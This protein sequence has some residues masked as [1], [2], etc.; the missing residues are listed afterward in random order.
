MRSSVVLDGKRRTT[1]PLPWEIY[2]HADAHYIPILET[3]EA[4]DTLQALIGTKES[5][6]ALEVSPDAFKG[7]RQGRFAVKET[8]V[9]RLLLTASLIRCVSSAGVFNPLYWFFQPSGTLSATLGYTYSPAM[10]LSDDMP[11]DLVETACRRE[12]AAPQHS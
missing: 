3:R 5:A 12:N 8:R 10:A 1:W 9:E 6:R 11:V 7:W 4:L 2:T